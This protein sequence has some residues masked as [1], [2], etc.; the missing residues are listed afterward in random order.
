MPAE[1]LSRMTEA[2]GEFAER[3]FWLDNKDVADNWDRLTSESQD[4]Y[5]EVLGICKEGAKLVANAVLN[6]LIEAGFLKVR[7]AP[8]RRYREFSQGLRKVAKRIDREKAAC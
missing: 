8:D 3:C 5:V 2:A 7:D 6:S 1:E 4:D